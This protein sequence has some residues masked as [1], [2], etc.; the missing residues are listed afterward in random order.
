MRA[1]AVADRSAIARP[2]LT[3]RTWATPVTIGAF[4]LMATT[5]V[6]RFFGW[7]GGLTSEAHEWLSWLFLAGVAAHLAVNWRPLTL[8]LRSRWGKASIAAAMTVLAFAVFPSGTLSPHQLH[9]RIEQAVIDAPLSTVA[10]LAQF[11][12]AELESRLKA[13]GFEAS[14]QQSVRE[15]AAQKR[16]NEREVLAIAFRNN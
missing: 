10:G 9:S 15:L 13:H 1:V 16:T 3:L 7:R 5:G 12:P 6:L 4:V 14:L 2:N 8:H 11:A